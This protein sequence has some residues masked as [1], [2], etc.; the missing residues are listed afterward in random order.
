RVR[1]AG[2]LRLFQAVEPHM[3][4]LVSIKLYAHD[5]AEAQGAFRAAFDRIAKLDGILS[6]YKHDS[7]LNR[8]TRT[9]V[10]RTVQVSEDLFRVLAASQE[11]AD[12]SGGAFDITI[13]P[14]V[15]LW[16]DARN[17]N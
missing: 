14:V 16:R 13:G 5:A 11:L 17:E 3:G 6:D 15:G 8:I 7:E 12:S 4:T 2:G 1:A 10:H 9:A